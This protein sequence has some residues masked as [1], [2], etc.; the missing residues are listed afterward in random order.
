MAGRR[1][2]LVAAGAL[3]AIAVAVRLVGLGWYD[4]NGDEAFRLVMA[5]HL[6]L[7]YYDEAAGVAWAAALAQGLFGTGEGGLRVITALAGAG[8]CLALGAIALLV[9]GRRAALLALLVG[10]AFPAM[11]LASRRLAGDPLAQLFLLTAVAL[12]IA[13]HRRPRLLPL[14][15]L[16]LGLATF[17]HY[18]VLPAAVGLVAY[19]AWTR[20]AGWVSRW[21]ALAIVFAGLGVLPPAVLLLGS[22]TGGLGV[23]LDTVGGGLGPSVGP[24]DRLIHLGEAA[25]WPFV[26]I[27]AAGLWPPRQGTWRA[28]HWPAALTLLVY[29]AVGGDRPGDGLSGMLPALALGCARV[30]Q[31]L[32]EAGWRRGAGRIGWGLAGLGAA[33]GLLT[34]AAALGVTGIPSARFLERDRESRTWDA[35]GPAVARVAAGRSV[36]TVDPDLAGLVAFYAHVPAWTSYPGFARLEPRPS[37]PSLLLSSYPGAL[38]APAGS[39][40]LGGSAAGCRTLLAWNRDAGAPAVDYLTLYRAGA[41]GTPATGCDVPGPKGWRGS[42]SASGGPGSG[43]TL[44]LQKGLHDSATGEGW[45]IGAPIA[46]YADGQFVSGG[47]AVIAGPEPVKIFA[48]D[49]VDRSH[50]PFALFL[51]AEP[52]GTVTVT[53]GPGG[54]IA[55]DP[56]RLAREGLR[57]LTLANETGGDGAHLFLPGHP[58]F[59]PVGAGP[60]CLRA[61]DGSLCVSGAPGHAGTEVS[62]PYLN[63]AGVDVDLDPFHPSSYLARFT[64]DLLVASQQPVLS[65]PIAAGGHIAWGE[66]GPGGRLWL[67][68]LEGQALPGWPIAFPHGLFDSPVL[69]GEGAAL[70]VVVGDDSGRLHAFDIGGHELPGWPVDLGYKIWTSPTLL[71]GGAI[72]VGDRDRMHVFGP[73]GREVDGWPQRMDG[74]PIATP[75]FNSHILA[76]STL[77]IGSQRRGWV[78]EW[79]LD[80]RAVPGFPVALADDSDSSPTFLGDGSVLVA[81]SSGRSFRISAGGVLTQL[82]GRAS[83]PIEASFT[84]AG[85]LAVVGSWDRRLRA[86]DVASGRAAWT[87]SAQ[88]HIIASAAACSIDG[89]ASPDFLV[90]SKDGRLYAFDVRGAPVA[91]FPIPLG[92]RSYS[93]PWVGDLDGDG[94]ADVVVGA[95][96]G[97]HILRDVGVLGD[98]PWPMFRRD[99]GH[100]GTAP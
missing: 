26:P 31:V 88:D 77:L 39:R 54:A 59:A 56:G 2:L 29:L 9:R 17:S 16:A 55:V 98:C 84:V 41:L 21:G 66:W 62:P 19:G 74:W 32:E 48:F 30:D 23:V 43:K 52:R 34:L 28:A 35:L 33:L 83:L 90:G 12:A 6:A 57:S 27:L 73:D 38:P 86:W 97:V 70:R 4:L 7:A 37:G 51:P 68:D 50:R 58:V 82:P 72:A 79:T 20:P 44:G 65:S 18:S 99:P 81:D 22:G 87:A 49:R 5:H 3:I 46:G 24:W 94:M 8:A 96:N 89:G 13:A 71:P 67:T 75:A 60:T 42:L 1:G 36:E 10:A 69:T 61:A 85:G 47:A 64:P 11:L 45:G 100:S 15:G 40:I 95:A 93:S 92:G 76:V 25:G 78:Y 80:G 91:G 53:Y 14:A 63:W